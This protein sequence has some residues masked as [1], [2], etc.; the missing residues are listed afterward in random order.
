MLFDLL[1]YML[2]GWVCAVPVW[3]GLRFVGQRSGLWTARLCYL[4]PYVAKA[5]R[6]VLPTAFGKQG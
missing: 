5:P 2:L 4:R 3:R 1:V 6:P